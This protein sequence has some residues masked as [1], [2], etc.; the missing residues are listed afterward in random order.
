[1]GKQASERGTR[2][3]GM[4]AGKQTARKQR[5]GI[6]QPP[7]DEVVSTHHWTRGGG[8]KKRK[9][10]SAGS[11]EDEKEAGLTGRAPGVTARVTIPSLLG[12]STR[13]IAGRLL[14]PKNSARF[15]PSL[16]AC[17]A[18]IDART[19]ASPWVWALDFPL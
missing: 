9:E 1:M 3:A 16:L 8:E 12:R 5:A 7:T 15:P 17:F 10:E 6:S 4:Q 13:V 19:Q 2:L 11:K 18:R 14:A